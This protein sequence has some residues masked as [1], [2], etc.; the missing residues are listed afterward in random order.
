MA[1][2]VRLHGVTPDRRGPGIYGIIKTVIH[3][4]TVIVLEQD[5]KGDTYMLTDETAASDAAAVDVI[6]AQA[7]AR[8]IPADKVWVSRRNA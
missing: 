7:A 6:N 5:D 2:G 8:G 1:G 4:V 3:G